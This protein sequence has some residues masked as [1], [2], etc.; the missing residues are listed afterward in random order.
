MMR[1]GLLLLLQ[2]MW[3][4]GRLEWLFYLVPNCGNVNVPWLVGR[5]RKKSIRHSTA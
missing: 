4:P 1:G 5:R 2:S 3:V